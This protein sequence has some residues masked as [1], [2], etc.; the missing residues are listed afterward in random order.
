[1]LHANHFRFYLA[2]DTSQTFG[3]VNSALARVRRV[4]RQLDA[5]IE[6]LLHQ[7]GL[8]GLQARIYT[9]DPAFAGGNPDSL[10]DCRTA[11]ARYH[12]FR[13]WRLTQS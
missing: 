9:T 7:L 11:V 12:D 3:S 4:E 8:A 13:Q 2:R 1:M 6:A 5:D 10:A